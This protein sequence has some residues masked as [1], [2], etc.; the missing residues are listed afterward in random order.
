MTYEAVKS[1]DKYGTNFIYSENRRKYPR[2][3][4]VN[5]SAIF[6]EENMFRNKTERRT[7]IEATSELSPILPI[8]QTGKIR[9][10]IFVY[11]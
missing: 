2:Q 7:V 3:Y 5:C 9:S 4:K 6:A 1:Q 11:L 8:S 10:A